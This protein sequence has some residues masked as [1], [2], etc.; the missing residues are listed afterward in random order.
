MPSYSNSSK[1]EVGKASTERLL[2]PLWFSGIKQLLPSMAALSTSISQCRTIY[3]QSSKSWSLCTGIARCK[4]WG[5]QFCHYEPWVRTISKDQHRY[6]KFDCSAFMPVTW[7]KSTFWTL[8]P[9]EGAGGEL[10]C[11][12][13]PFPI[14]LPTNLFSKAGSVT[15]A[16]MLHSLGVCLSIPMHMH[17]WMH[18]HMLK[19]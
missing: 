4:G 17:V 10:I 9:G 18:T 8:L 2:V 16:I 1:R 11:K 5:L 14:H 7:C 6:K 13:L 15:A 3:D 12:Q 19:L